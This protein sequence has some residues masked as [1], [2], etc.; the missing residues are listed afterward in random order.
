MKKLLLILIGLI[1]AGVVYWLVAPLFIDKKVSEDLSEIMKPADLSEEASGEALEQ[2]SLIRE[3]KSGVFSG[4]DSLHKGS[5]SVKILESGGKYFVRF[6]EDFQVTNGPDL[7]VHFGKDGRYEKSA[8]LGKL[9]GNIGSQ[10]YEVPEG[11]NIEDFNEIWI[12]CRAFSVP[13]AKAS[14]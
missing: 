8:N 4:F 13:F 3:V 10:N 6:E 12:W 9:K 5:G 14:F 2:E 11:I 1:V 7:F